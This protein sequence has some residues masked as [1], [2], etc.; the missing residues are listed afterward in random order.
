[1]ID[2]HGDEVITGQHD[3]GQLF[4]ALAQELYTG[5]LSD[6][7]DSLGYREQAMHADIRPVWSGAVVV[8]RAHTIL[9]SDIYHLPDDPYSMEI[10]AI[11]SVPRNGVVVAGTNR[12][13]RT[14]LWGE[15]LSTATRAR[16]GRG[17]ILDGHTRDVRVIEQM[18]FPVFSTGMRP[19]DSKGRG[20]IVAIGEPVE[21]GGVLVRPGELVFADVDGIVV[22]PREDEDEVIR[23]AREKASGENA[24][25]AWLVEGRTLREAFDHFGL[26]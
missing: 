3:E 1:M 9:S 21:C 10:K 23:L 2:L 22:I 14:C 16:G 24:M 8:G 20:M 15:L 6:V 5:V 25:R 17:A 18:Q 19:V 4:D 26:L 11:D 12:S 7:L 13:T